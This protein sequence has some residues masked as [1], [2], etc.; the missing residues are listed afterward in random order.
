[1]KKAEKWLIGIAI[2]TLGFMGFQ[3]VYGLLHKETRN[4]DQKKEYVY[5]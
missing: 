1:M 2:A 4:N 5:K 3:F